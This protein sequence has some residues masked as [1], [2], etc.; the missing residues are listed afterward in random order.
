M[1]Y[2]RLAL[3]QS[4]F[5][6]VVIFEKVPNTIQLME[7]LRKKQLFYIKCVLLGCDARGLTANYCFM[8]AK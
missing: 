4:C 1:K 6:K 7:I 3:L 8:N 5:P 2:N